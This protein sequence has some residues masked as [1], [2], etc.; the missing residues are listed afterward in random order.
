MNHYGEKDNTFESGSDLIGLMFQ[1]TNVRKPLLAKRRLVE[2]NIVQ[3]GHELETNFIMNVES[4]RK[5]MMKGKGGSFV[6]LP[7]R[8]GQRG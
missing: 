4:D 3:C 7:S 6:F 2:T 1:V 8:P 5:I